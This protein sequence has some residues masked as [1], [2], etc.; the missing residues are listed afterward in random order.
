MSSEIVLEL[1]REV[2]LKDASGAY[3]AG[4]A[5]TSPWNKSVFSANPSKYIEPCSK[6]MLAL[7]A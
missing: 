7:N 5:T 4:Y 6:C 3:A 1:E 2:R